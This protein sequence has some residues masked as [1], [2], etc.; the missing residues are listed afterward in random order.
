M[1]K[2]K[3]GAC[4]VDRGERLKRK[5]LISEFCVD[6]DRELPVQRYPLPTAEV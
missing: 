5:P 3:N 1:E 6:T 2:E 4:L